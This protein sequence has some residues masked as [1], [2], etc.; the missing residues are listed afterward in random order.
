MRHPGPISCLPQTRAPIGRG[1]LDPVRHRDGGRNRTTNRR[2]SSFGFLDRARGMASERGQERNRGAALSV[3]AQRRGR[4]PDAAESRASSSPI[5]LTAPSQ[6][7]VMRPTASPA[8]AAMGLRPGLPLRQARPAARPAA[9]F[10][11]PS[12]RRAPASH[13]RRRRWEKGHAGRGVERVGLDVLIAIPS[14]NSSSTTAR[15]RR[16]KESS[17]CPERMNAICRVSRARCPLYAVP[18]SPSSPCALGAPQTARRASRLRVA[19]M[20]GQLSNIVVCSM[21][22]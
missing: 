11:A 20:L 12:H 10:T 17:N 18:P 8:A 19:E 15:E 5:V 2:A 13:L 21:R 14:V 22:A 9:P 4:R 16:F 1:A 3:R 6:G 7:P